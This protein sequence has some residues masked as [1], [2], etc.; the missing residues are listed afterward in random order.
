MAHSKKSAASAAAIRAVH[1]LDEA[2][3]RFAGDSGDGMQLVG[4]RF[5][6]AC[7]AVGNDLSTLPD[8]PSE[9]RAP[10]GTLAGVSGFQVRF[11]KH[12]IHTPGDVLD[13]LVAM[14]PAALRANLPDLAAGGILVLNSDAFEAVELERAGYTTNPLGDGTLAA[15]RVLPVAMHRLHKEAVAAV[16]LSPREVERSRNFFALGLACWLFDRPLE[17][18][19]RWIRDKFAKNPA[20]LEAN[21]RTLKAGYHHGETAGLLPM[22]YRVGAGRLPPGRYRKITGNEAISLGLVTASRLAELPLVFACSPSTPASDV[23]QHLVDLKSN[24]VRIVQAEDEAAALGMA[25]GAAFAGALA[26]TATSGPGMSVMSEAIGLAVMTELPCVIIDVQRGGPSTGLP[27][28]SEQADLFQALVGRHGEAPLPVL[29]PAHPSDCFEVALEAVRLALRYMTPVIVLSDAHLAN[30]AKPW[31]VPAPE[32]LPAIHT[33][34][35]A[36]PRGDQNC[37]LPYQRDTQGV[38]PWAPAG[39]PGLEHRIGGLEKEPATGHVSYEPADHEAMVQQRQAK[40]DS[41]AAELPPLEVH[42]A[43]DGD[44]LVLGWGGTCGAIRSA[45]ERCQKNGHAVA[46]AHLRYLKPLPRNL[47]DILG[48]YPRVLVPELNQG[49]LAWMLQACYPVKVEM[50]NKV[51]GQPFLIADIENR[52]LELLAERP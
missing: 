19:L 41:I 24:G 17:P 32:E 40:I 44:L 29:A 34:R 20:I 2:T 6:A 21:T 14:N 37:F 36:A 11:S 46:V 50:L 26:A 8:F 49:Q 10:A 18:T 42:G 16:K 9:I 25:L 33:R 43:T 45:V 27:T 30:G 22:Q 15:Y 28:K 1:D 48:R 51:R 38:R 31:K 52:I 47:G 5:T 23:L 7:A 4:A 13:A 35:V 39:T 3:I 12:E